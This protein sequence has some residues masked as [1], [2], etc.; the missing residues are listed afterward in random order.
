MLPELAKAYL[1]GRMM[2]LL[3]AGASANSSDQTG[4]PLP[5]S[6]ELASEMAKISAFDYTGE[7]LSLVYSAVRETD[8]AALDDFLTRR[9]T[10]T[11]PG[12]DLLDLLRYRWSRV[13]TLNIDDGVE[14]AARTTSPQKLKVFGRLDRLVELDPVFDDLHLVKLNGSADKLDEGLIF[15]PQEYGAGSAN[16]PPWYRELG[17]NYSSHVFVFIGSKLNEPL[18]QH[19]MAVM[20]E[21]SHR[22]PQRG[23]LISP[24]VTAIEVRHLE[25]LKITHIPGSLADFVNGSKPE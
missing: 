9:L 16:V 15:A 21:G 6:G 24:H 18:L 19:V 14:V 8:S 17:Q 22:N 13:Y 23:Y 25:S 20:R 10:H 12:K 4:M 5:M 3:G 2:L 11:K 1:D 7:Q